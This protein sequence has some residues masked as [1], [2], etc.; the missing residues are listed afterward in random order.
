MHAATAKAA[1]ATVSVKRAEL[2]AAI[3]RA[4]DEEAKADEQ[5]KYMNAEIFWYKPFL[6]HDF[7]RLNKKAARDLRKMKQFEEQY[8]DTVDPLIMLGKNLVTF[9]EPTR[10][11]FWGRGQDAVAL[12]LT[13]PV[14]PSVLSRWLAH[15]FAHPCVRT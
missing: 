3:A 2:D 8:P 7:A 1:N 4:F 13:R 5:L 9:F 10:G 14:F 15:L 12:I 6:Q 11:P